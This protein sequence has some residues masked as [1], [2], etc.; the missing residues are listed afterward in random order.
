MSG[1]FKEELVK[2]FSEHVINLNG[3]DYVGL[4]V[5]QSAVSEIALLESILGTIALKSKNELLV[6]DEETI[7]YIS[8]KHDMIDILYENGNYVIKKKQYLE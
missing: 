2:S 3:K 1:S 6:S 4:E 5:F 8:E 7:E